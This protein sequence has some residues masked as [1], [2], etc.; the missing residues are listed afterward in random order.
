MH[1]NAPSMPQPHILGEETLAVKT[2]KSRLAG[3][4]AC[5]GDSCRFLCLL[6]R[7]C[8]VLQTLERK[9]YF[10]QYGR[11]LKIA[12]SRSNSAISNA[13]ATMHGPTA[14]V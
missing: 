7:C 12:V 6:C 9:E 4:V 8:L 11:I 1:Q 13:S 2:L 3:R 10:G 14:N 5:Y